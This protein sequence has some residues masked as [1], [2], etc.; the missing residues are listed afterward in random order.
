L[1]YFT[2]FLVVQSAAFLCELWIAHPATPCKAL[3]LGVLMAGALLLAPCLWLAIEGGVAG[4]APRPRGLPRARSLMLGAGPPCA[5]ALRMPGHS[6]PPFANPLAPSSWLWSRFI[7]TTM[8]VCIAI[9]VAQVPWSLRRC[10][11]LLL[12]RLDGRPRHWAA[13]PLAI[14]FTTWA[15]A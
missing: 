7:H 9:F 14:V 4:S 15:L 13:W 10:R 8:L 5:L 11:T 2:A 12:S 1:R 3:G 6:G